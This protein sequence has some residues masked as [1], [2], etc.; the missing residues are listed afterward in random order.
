MTT[1][2]T[3]AI[4]NPFAYGS[5]EGGKGVSHKNIFPFEQTYVESASH[6][7]IPSKKAP[8]HPT[9]P[10]P[11][12]VLIRVTQKDLSFWANLSR[13]CKSI[14]DTFQ[15]GTKAFYFTQ[16][17]F[18]YSPLKRRKGL[19]TQTDLSFRTN[20]SGE[21]KSSWDAFYEDSQ[22]SFLTQSSTH[23]P[24]RLLKVSVLQRY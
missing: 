4:H 14:W 16:Y 22:A 1:L 7:E 18:A 3:I 20:L 11:L 24:R 13:E 15:E 10:N 23:P 6:P 17:L 19:L 21:R 8:K 5:S 12:Q 9:S 2:K